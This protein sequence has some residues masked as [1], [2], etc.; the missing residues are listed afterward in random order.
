LLS[1]MLC[2]SSAFAQGSIFG[3]VANS[4]ASTP[5]NGEI[6]FIGFLDDTDEEVRIESCDGAGYDAGNWFDDFQNYLTEAP[7][8]PYDYH[9]FN[10]ANGEVFHLAG[11]VPSNSFQQENVVLAP[12]VW[13]DAPVGLTGAAMSATAVVISWDFAPGVTYH[14]YRRRATSNGSFF[15]LDNPAGSLA[16]RGVAENFYVDLTVDGVSS[17]NYLVV[18][19]D[20]AGNLSPHSSILTVDAGVLAAPVLVS[21]DPSNG[22]NNGGTLVNVY[23]SGFDPAG[24]SVNFGASAAAGTVISPFHITVTTPTGAVGAADVTVTN[25][26]SALA[27]NTLVGAFTYDANTNPILA[28]IGA[29]SVTEGLL[30]EFTTSASD[31][32]GD[33]PILTSTALPAGATYV[34]NGDG[35]AL[36]SWTP[37]FT[38]AGIYPVTFYATD[39]IDAAAVDS[40]A[41]D[42]TVVE[43]GNQAPVMAAINDTTVQETQLL[44]LTVSA[45][46]P[47]GEIP[48]LSVTDA[49]LNATFVDNGD[50]TGSFDFTPDLT[51]SGVYNVIFKAVDAGLEV[52][53]I[54]VAITVTEVNQEPVLA[55]IGAQTGTENVLLSFTVSAADGDGPTPILTTSA[56]PGTAVFTDSLNGIGLFE[57]TP[58][59]TDAGTYNVTFYATDSAITTAI[60]SEIVVITINEAGNQAPVLAAIGAQTID[61]GAALNLTLTATD[62]DGTTPTFRAEGLPTNATLLDN[63]DGTATFDFIPDYTQAGLYS[64]TFITEDGALAD[65][66]IVDITVNDAGNVAPVIDSLGDF[67]VDEG[68]Q[69]LI[70]V[71]A[72][73]PDG[74]GIFPALSVTTTLNNFTFVDNGD[75][76]GLLTYNPDYFD[77]GLD[78]VIF[79]A[80]D[81][82]TPQRV[83]S[84]V[85]QIQTN[86]INLAPIWDSTGPFGVAVGDT[87]TFTVTATD[88]SDANTIHRLFLSVVSA[89]A[90][91]N[92]T[93]NGDGTGTFVFRP[94]ATQ[95]GT[96]TVR[97]L[98]VDQGVPQLSSNLNVTVTVVTENIPPVIDLI[99]AQTVVEGELL[100]IGITAS[101]PD[102]PAPVLDT[103]NAPA[104]SDF[105]DNGDG[106]ATFTYTPNFLGGTRLSSV[107]FT[108]YDGI[109]RVRTQPILIQIYDAGDQ[110]P[111]FDS[112]PSP[113]V[114]EGQTLEQIVTATD[115]DGGAVILAASGLP[116]NA[117][118]ADQGDGSG[119]LTFT[120]DYT[121]AGTYPVELIVYD[122]PIGDDTTLADTATM[123]LTVT[124]AGNQPLTLAPIGN[125]VVN[126]GVTLE[127]TITASDPDGT[128]ATLTAAPL[129]ANA[130]LTDNGD[131]TGRFTFT[132]DFFQA[133]TYDITFT[134]SDGEFLAEETITIT[135]NDVNRLP[136]VFA[137]GARDL[138]EGDTLVYQ[139]ESFDADLTYPIL[140]A[141]L[142]GTDSIL[143]DSLPANMTFEDTRDGFGTLTFMPSWDQGGPASN[144]ILYQ[145]RFKAVDE[146]YPA[147]YQ[148][149]GSVA[150]RV[151]DRNWPPEVLFPTG[152]G[153]F[154]AAEGDTV[155]FTVGAYDPDGTT[156]ASLIALNMPDSNAVFAASLGFG[157]FEFYPDYT[158]AGSYD[159]TF[160]GTDDRG[161][162][163]TAIVHIDITEVGNQAPYFRTDIQPVYNVPAGVLFQLRL[164]ALDPDL[165]SVIISS[166]PPLIDA[167][168]VDSGNATAVFSY[169]PDASVVG[170]VFTVNFVVTDFPGGVADTVTT[171]FA[172]VTYLRGDLDDND[173]YT[174]NDLVF[175]ISYLF[176]QGP[177]PLVLESGDVDGDGSINVADVSYLIRFM[178][179]GGP[180]PAP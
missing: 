58:L 114:E 140:S 68:Q 168:L 64:V 97:F 124:D 29:Q 93:D 141:F 57:W 155:R 145:I 11:A 94:D 171:Q 23:G 153:P 127:F 176:R 26:A 37:T 148:I 159:I 130:T 87:L 59:F 17:Y 82:G 21:I 20:G 177:A 78:S 144:P 154:T 14:V 125:R 103:S 69:L 174:M 116:T 163:D 19:D 149:T 67:A 166:Y 84:T 35:T 150:F 8:N 42:I 170:S 10:T 50:G 75:G 76:T 102:G 132:P 135:V 36:F 25:T 6:T 12:G 108:A 158:Q 38:D 137:D 46:D 88:S 15:R 152:A 101:D 162:A 33:T 120:P 129:P 44:T 157:T 72:S 39:P 47:D 90:N 62:P 54:V 146:D 138:F 16:D 53:S 4:D 98:A 66:E 89:P 172:P 180:P 74:G 30:L 5:A 165:D 105:F 73:D 95:N 7:G 22:T 118:F 81:F 70:P 113:T 164:D 3:T 143:A 122:G 179:Y 167:N 151:T 111:A 55:A 40:E 134:A 28:A 71:T 139:V 126:E 109:I 160:I 2:S 18:A 175:M 52:D 107:Q 169:L 27:S 156:A 119:L 65:S 147:V 96:F 173:R 128:F 99:P 41:V 45:T 48:A 61:E 115:P 85:S 49:P 142:S 77:G 1:L 133:G 136:F 31:V 24:V 178:Y 79:F 63:A 86:E 123:V 32:D 91:S 13:P 43:A 51:Q 110:I 80:T 34:D 106:T 131:N 9:F 83:A 56:L 112:I 92:F 121:Q 60:D 104:G 117:S 100:T 161:A